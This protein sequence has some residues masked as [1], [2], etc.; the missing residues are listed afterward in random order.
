MT[1]QQAI[2][3]SVAHWKRMIKWVIKICVLNP[4]NLFRRPSPDGMVLWI[5]EYW[6]A[7]D[8]PLCRLYQWEIC[9]KCPLQLKY[10][11]CGNNEWDKVNKAKTW[12]TWLYHAFGML[13]QLKSL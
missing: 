9:K 11:H 3:E 4:F 8:C 6:H 13:R 2:S 7:E 5:N 1:E 10:G 12:L